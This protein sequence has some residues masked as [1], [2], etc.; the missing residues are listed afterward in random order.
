MVPK[1]FSPDQAFPNPKVAERSTISGKSTFL[2]NSLTA[3]TPGMLNLTSEMCNGLQ[4]PQFPGEFCASQTPASPPQCALE[5]E[6]EVEKGSPAPQSLGSNLLA[7]KCP[8]VPHHTTSTDHE[9]HDDTTQHDYSGSSLEKTFQKNVSDINV[10][11]E[12]SGYRS[13][14]AQALTNH[15]A[16]APFSS[17]SEK[18]KTRTIAQ[19]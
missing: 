11:V 4:S 2:R 14:G 18:P 1:L 9:R 10:N 17:T 16:G 7:P 19:K 3:A 15:M 13:V 5:E 12:G 6:G 8:V